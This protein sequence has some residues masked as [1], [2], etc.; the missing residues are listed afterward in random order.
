MAQETLEQTQRRLGLPTTVNG[1]ATPRRP[2]TPS[3]FPAAPRKRSGAGGVIAVAA[4]LV[5]LSVAGYSAF[6]GSGLSLGGPDWSQYPGTYLTPGEQALAA[7]SLEVTAANADDLLA[8]LQDELAEYG[9]VWQ[10]LY[11]AEVT[12]NDNG[13]GGA[14]MLQDYDSDTL[15]GSAP[16]TTPQARAQIAAI[17]AEVMESVNDSTVVVSNDEITDEDAEYYYGST[18]R[19]RQALWSMWTYQY[20]FSGLEADLDVYDATVETD[21]DFYGVYWLPDDA[22]GQLFVYLHLTA[23]DQLSAGDRAAFREALEPFA[24][25]TPP[26]PSY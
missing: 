4:V 15:L 23:R 9:F 25:R 3:P 12:D 6:A 26:D 2:S 11:P 22:S 20:D 7:D 1:Q 21:D 13:Y 19:D 16:A 17:F 8:R 10:V 14:S 5:G 24:G 18:N